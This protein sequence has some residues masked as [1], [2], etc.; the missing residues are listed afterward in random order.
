MDFLA[1]LTP[2]AQPPIAVQPR[3]GA[4]GGPVV[5]TPAP[6]GGGTASITASNTMLSW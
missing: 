1:P 5:A 3:H 6:R 4:C 2:N